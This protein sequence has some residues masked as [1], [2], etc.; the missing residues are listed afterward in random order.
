MDSP[1]RGTSVLASFPGFSPPRE[2]APNRASSDILSETMR[3]RRALI[4]SAAILAGVGAACAPPATLGSGAYPARSLAPAGAPPY[5]YEVAAGP[6]GQELAI[7]VY[8]PAGTT[9]LRAARA[10]LPFL[11]D[12]S[13][14]LNEGVW[15]PLTTADGG[16][17]LAGCGSAPCR[18]RYRVLLGE[19]ARTLDD[20]DTALVHRGAV[21][22]PSSTWLLKPARPLSDDRFR[23]HVTTSPGVNY[24]N[25]LFPA[26][27]A[28]DIQE[29]RIA[30]L[31][32]SPYAAFGLARAQR[33]VFAGGEITVAMSDGAPA[34]GR[35]A[36][37]SWIE[38]RAR[39]VADYYG[40]F[41]VPHAALLVLFEQ[42]HDLAGS[43]M[44][45]G[46]A[47][48]MV[49][50]DEKST[51][52]ALDDDW[53]LVHELVHVAFPNVGKAWVEEGLASY[54]EPLIRVRAGLI[55]SDHLY[56]DLL[57]GLPQGQPQ[58]GDR[59]LDH[60]DTWGRRYWGGALFWFLADVAIRKSTGNA[61]SLDGALRR[62]VAQGG[63][64]SVSW[65]VDR[66]LE[67]GDRDAG[68]TVLRDLRHKLGDAAVT[69][70]L[71]ALWN[72]LGVH[73]VNG[74]V[75]YDDTAPL[76]AIRKSIAAPR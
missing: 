39:A 18:A 11:R 35:E 57:D 47:S 55:S 74:K 31:E 29:G 52:A 44:G 3:R 71:E 68:G 76:A 21:L 75:I 16:F 13:M 43:T 48:V 6:G 58:P 8:L 46:G 72:E 15:L 7:T 60:T 54:V 9:H 67:E 19:A 5:R 42:D 34:L 63:N 70:D 73:L 41:P 45:S 56:R 33:V 49:S 38:V 27:D 30:D 66:T 12:V 40:R 28:P 25:G 22:A 32:G 69:T 37:E 10:M 59:G 36:I 1:G 2:E 20:R 51:P 65:T 53:I 62:I 50:L 24:V 26:K 14:S 17:D 64:V 4:L 61:H 23:L